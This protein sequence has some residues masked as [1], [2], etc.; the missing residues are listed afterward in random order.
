MGLIAYSWRLVGEVRWEL[1]ALM[2]NLVASVAAGAAA[3]VAVD[4]LEGV[5]GLLA[6][7][8]CAT[9]LYL[10]AAWALRMLAPDD[11]DWLGEI[12]ESRLGLRAKR[13]VVALAR[14]H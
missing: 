2:R 3:W 5:A 8:A 11:A 9:A 7:L 4:A 10:L 12:A 13:A 14:G 6:G 1:T